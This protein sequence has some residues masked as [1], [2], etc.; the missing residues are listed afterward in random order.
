M[1]GGIVRQI[2]FCAANDGSQL[3]K[4]K[5]Y[6]E[7]LSKDGCLGLAPF[8]FVDSSNTEN[9]LFPK[10]ILKV[11]CPN[12][13]PSDDE[14]VGFNYLQATTDGK[15]EFYLQLSNAEEFCARE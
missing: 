3:G 9:L 15:R 7:V 4:S 1:V 13:K 12:M 2:F 8:E 11:S 6:A 10:I 5:I 14:N